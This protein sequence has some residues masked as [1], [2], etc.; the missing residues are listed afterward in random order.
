MLGAG[1]TAA[2]G[3]RSRGAR[4]DSS[5]AIGRVEAGLQ[6]LEDPIDLDPALVH[7]DIALDA[8]TQGLACNVQIQIRLQIGKLGPHH[9]EMVRLRPHVHG[10]ELTFLQDDAARDVQWIAAIVEQAHAIDAHL[11][12]VE[13]DMGVELVVRGLERI[14]HEG[15]VPD[16]QLAIETRGLHAARDAHVPGERARHVAKRRGQSLDE[17]QL[18]G[19]ALQTQVERIR[20]TRCGLTAQLGHGHRAPHTQRRGFALTQLQVDL[21]AARVVVD[22]GVERLEPEIPERAVIDRCLTCGARLVERASERR[23]AGQTACQ[24]AIAH[25]QVV[26][27]REIDVRRL[28]ADARG[29]RWARGAI[30]RQHA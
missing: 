23:L 13:H 30:E 28:H 14:H 27:C 8:G 16:R 22:R 2:G 4:S 24:P 9:A 25:G 20:I 18:D 15:A 3:A 11:V 1:T 26:K 5:P 17:T 21:R 6:V 19:T 7:F 12:T 10:P 29:R